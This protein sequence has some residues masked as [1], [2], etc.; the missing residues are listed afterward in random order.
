MVATRDQRV[1]R[2]K[3]QHASEQA[4]DARDQRRRRTEDR[5]G[6][7]EQDTVHL[8]LLDTLRSPSSR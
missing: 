1:A 7:P 6:D 8:T 2:T 3:K 4:F 5:R